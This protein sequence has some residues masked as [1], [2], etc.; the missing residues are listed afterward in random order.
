MED[1]VQAVLNGRTKPEA[2]AAQA[3]KD[4]DALMRP[5][6]ERTALKLPA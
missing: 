2:G 5:Y 4:A 1:Q 6:L 3:Q